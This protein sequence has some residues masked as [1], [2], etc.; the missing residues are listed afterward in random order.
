MSPQA[1]I[2]QK[3]TSWD[4][5]SLTGIKPKLVAQSETMQVTAGTCLELFSLAGRFLT[6]TKACYSKGITQCEKVM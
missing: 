3:R 5:C 6:G 4:A 2:V 1:F